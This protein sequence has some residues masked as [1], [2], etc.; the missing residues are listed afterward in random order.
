MPNALLD[1]PLSDANHGKRTMYGKH[2][3]LGLSDENQSLL[4]EAAVALGIVK[5][6]WNV[7]GDWNITPQE[8]I[9]SGWTQIFNGVVFATTLASD[10]SSVCASHWS[11]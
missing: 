11:T 2:V 1:E 5:S 6:P 8:L 9:A 3:W 10:A 7:A 4:E